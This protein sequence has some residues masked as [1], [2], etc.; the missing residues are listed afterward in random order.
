MKWLNFT[1]PSKSVLY[2]AFL[3]NDYGVLGGEFRDPFPRLQ[4]L[5][6]NMISS[7]RA[8]DTGSFHP[9]TRRFVGKGPESVYTSLWEV[10]THA[11]SWK[12]L[13]DWRAHLGNS[14]S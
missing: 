14:P 10:D 3:R 12:Q 6:E 4:I 5:W 2:P 8:E 7:E 13:P 9:N 1:Q 11:A